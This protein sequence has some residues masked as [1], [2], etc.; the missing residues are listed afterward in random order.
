MLK[1]EVNRSFTLFNREKQGNLNALAEVIDL[2]MM[3]S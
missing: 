1:Q 2:M 3:Q